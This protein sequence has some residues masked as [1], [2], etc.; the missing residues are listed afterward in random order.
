MKTTIRTLMMLSVCMGIVS[1]TDDLLTESL[2]PQE[3]NTEGFL[4]E[5][6]VNAPGTIVLDEVADTRNYS[7]TYY[8]DQGKFKLTTE[9]IDG[10][11]LGI[12]PDQGAQVEFP[13]GGANGNS[14]KF[15]GGG[16]A[17]KNSSS[18]A[19]YYPFSKK[20]YY[21]ENYYIITDYS[22][23]VQNGNLSSWHLGAYDFQA[24]KQKATPQNGSVTIDMERLGSILIFEITAPA[25]DNYT[26][27]RLYDNDNGLPFVSK[28]YLN[29]SGDTP[30]YDRMVNTTYLSLGLENMSASEGDVLWLYMMAFPTGD[31]APRTLMLRGENGVYQ[32]TLASKVLSKTKMWVVE[33]ME[34]YKITNTNLIAAAEQNGGNSGVSFVKDENGYVNVN[35]ATNREMMEKVISITIGNKSDTHALDDISFFPNLQ[36]LY[37][38]GNQLQNIDVTQN[39]ELSILNCSSNSLK[40]IDLSKNRKLKNLDISNNYIENPDISHNQALEVFKCSNDPALIKLDVTHNS[41]LTTL[42]C[43][44]NQILKSL[45]LYYNT[46]LQYL[47]CGNSDISHLDASNLTALKTLSCYNNKNLFDLNVTNCTALTSLSCY[48]CDLT[49]LDVSTCTKLSTLNCSKNSLTTLD[50][51]KNTALTS[52]NCSYNDFSELTIRTDTDYLNKLSTLNV[53]YCT[54]LKTLYIYG[55]TSSDFKTSTGSL[56]TLTLTGCTALTTLSCGGNKISSLNLTTL[57]NLQLLMCH[58]NQLTSLNVSSNTKLRYLSCY[59]NRLSALDITKCTSLK[60]NK[61]TSPISQVYCGRQWAD[62]SKTTEQALTLTRNSAN[63]TGTLM[64]TTTTNYNV[65]MVDSTN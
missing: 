22:G 23:Q 65:T 59:A 2:E 24:S 47:Y 58:G 62:A 1:C 39:P 32:A 26:E 6:I 14:A 29:I 34:D 8:D 43:T 5:I 64:N 15:D 57:T 61:T 46:K 36:E 54:N 42:Y 18:Y 60:L 21:A 10:D 17:L 48:G 53:S 51:S 55:N 4:K 40:S 28:G 11:T 33:D 20:N 41:A 44:N 52:L 31:D 35:D 19:A 25:T 13:I 49:D 50:V 12:F 9:W 37:C 30:E 45:N 63:N 56:S 16:W 3:T 27:L 38:Y 7:Y